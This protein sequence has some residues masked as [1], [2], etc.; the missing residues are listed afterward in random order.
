M[1]IDLSGVQESSRRLRVREED[2]PAEGDVLARVVGYETA[3]Q[4]E[5]NRARI[6][7]AVA[8]YK[9]HG[10]DTGS[11]E[12][13]IA[14]LTQKLMYGEAHLRAHPKDH[15]SRRGVDA[16]RTQRRKLLRY[17]KRKDHAAFVAICGR[18]SL[19]VRRSETREDLERQRQRRA[20]E[21]RRKVGTPS[22][23]MKKRLN[24]VKRKNE[25]ARA[26]MMK[27]VGAMV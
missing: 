12:V 18:L 11:T 21:L 23:T 14:V 16:W 9:R 26:K 5:I 20:D 1:G 2:A 8:S 4:A 6:E 19:P 13:Q 27:H 7:A 25:R 3:A 15:H 10:N 22:R 24:V 17:L